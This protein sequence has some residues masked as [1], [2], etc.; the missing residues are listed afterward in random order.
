MGVKQFSITILSANMN[1]GKFVPNR[2]EV[3]LINDFKEF[4]L[5]SQKIIY[6]LLIR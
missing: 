2:L 3:L 6:R 4:S 5:Q 1:F